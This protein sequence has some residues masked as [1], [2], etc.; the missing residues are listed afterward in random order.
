[1]PSE[2]TSIAPGVA[3]V[4]NT[5]SSIQVGG[6]TPKVVLLDTGA[7]LVILEVQ[8]T[9]KMGMLD[10]KLWKS[11]WQIHTASGSVKEVLWESS[12]FIAFN[13]MKVQ[14]GALLTSQMFS[15]QCHQLRCVHWARGL[16]STRFHN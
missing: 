6:H 4:N 9:K 16:V 15:H 11:M 10:S 1:V 12:D 7:Q 13:F 8:F 5:K 3:I 14:Y 2:R